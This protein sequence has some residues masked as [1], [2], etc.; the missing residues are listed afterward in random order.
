MRFATVYFL[1]SVSLLSW[2]VRETVE[3][4][5]LW[6]PPSQPP[7]GYY[8][9]TL[10]FLSYDSNLVVLFNAIC[11]GVLVLGSACKEVSTWDSLQR[12]FVVTFLST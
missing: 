1:A 12:A 5:R 11:A 4:V 3:G 10:E 7:L 6:L 9:L 2:V 8:D